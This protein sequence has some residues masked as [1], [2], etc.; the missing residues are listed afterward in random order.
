MTR[1]R[2]DNSGKGN[3]Q[4]ALLLIFSVP[5]TRRCYRRDLLLVS[6]W[7]D[8]SRLAWSSHGLRMKLLG[9]EKCNVRSSNSMT[10]SKHSKGTQ[11]GTSVHVPCPT[12]DSTN[13]SFD[14]SAQLG[15]LTPCIQ[16]HGYPFCIS[17]ATAYIHVD[18]LPALPPMVSQSLAA[19][20]HP[21]FDTPGTDALLSSLD[22]TLFCLSSCYNSLAVLR[23][24]LGAPLITLK[25]YRGA[26]DIVRAS[27][28][29]PAFIRERLPVYALATS[30]TG[31]GGMSFGGRGV[32]GVVTQLGQR[33]SVDDAWI[34]DVLGHGREAVG[35]W[36]VFVGDRRVARDEY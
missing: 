3:I 12:S 32:E 27:I 21:G 34:E 35:G 33:F 8:K 15:T 5:A 24:L 1:E 19:T 26:L 11:A 23:S 17:P 28:T 31:S 4:Q 6:F 16:F 30:F 9:G 20:Y 29:V 13:R 25:G 10:F 22:G 7:N 36:V 18:L 2:S 14:V